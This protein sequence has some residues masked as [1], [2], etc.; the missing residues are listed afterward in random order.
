[1][2]KRNIRLMK[3]SFL[4]WLPAHLVCCLASTISQHEAVKWNSVGKT[5]KQHPCDC[6]S[7]TLARKKKK[8]SSSKQWWLKR[9]VQCWICIWNYS[10]GS[11]S[12]L[13]RQGALF[14]LT[15]GRS[16]DVLARLLRRHHND[17]KRH[18][19]LAAGLGTSQLSGWW[20]VEKVKC[21]RWQSVP[22]LWPAAPGGAAIRHSNTHGSGKAE[23]HMPK[24]I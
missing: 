2:H 19:A 7:S 8:K 21:Q 5:I 18:P 15:K 13:K 12:F 23:P 22:S 10:V 3:S 11:S 9:E 24:V 14:C 20:K 16:V 4:P 17:T 1:M 6:E